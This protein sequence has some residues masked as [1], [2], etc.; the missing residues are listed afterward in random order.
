MKRTLLILLLSAPLI[1]MA[2]DDVYGTHAT[3][4]V[5][6]KTAPEK[7]ENSIIPTKEGVIFYEQIAQCTGNQKEL[8]LKARKWFV[9]TFH[10]A[11]SVLQMEDKE[12]GKLA[13]KAFHTYVFNNGLSSSNVAIDF[14]LNVD[15]KD[16]KYRVQFYDMYGANTNVNGGLAMLSALGGNYNAGSDATSV[17]K[18]EYNKVLDDYL[19]GKREKYNKKLLDGMNNE[20]KNLFASLEKVMKAPPADEF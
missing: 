7:K 13:G 19:S 8:Y 14:T 15:I 3:A 5:S 1:G 11:K 2:Q 9:D 17:R 16:G 20:V 18:I 4:R 12:D 10:N 6:E